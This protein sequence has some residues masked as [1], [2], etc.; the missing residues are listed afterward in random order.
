LGTFLLAAAG[1]FLTVSM[2]RAPDE[3]FSSALQGLKVWWEVV[4]PA[5]LPF[6]IGSEILMGLGVVNFMGVLLEPLMRPLFNVPGVGSFVM[7][8][9]LA[10]GYPIGAILTRKLRKQE[11]CNQVEAERLISFSNTADPLFMIGAVAVGM[12]GDARLGVVIAIAHYLAALAVGI[13][14]RFYRRNAPVSE[15]L[16]NSRGNIVV[17]AGKELYRARQRDGRPLGQLLGDAV[18]NSVN[19]L[20]MIG[21][22]IILFSVIMRIA[23]VSGLVAVVAQGVIGLLQMLGLSTNLS[24]AAVSGVFEITIG[25]N[26]ASQAVAPLAQRVIMAGAIIAWSGLSVHAQVAAVVN[27]TDIRILP[28]LCA[29]ALHAILAGLF[30]WLLWPKLS[31]TITSQAA[32]LPVFLQTVP[33]GS[34]HFWLERFLFMGQRVGLLLLVLLILSVAYHSLCRLQVVIWRRR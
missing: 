10:S 19:S 7:A 4:F 28:Y 2:V 14:M 11:L 26:V 31:P 30:T 12:F 3:A 29:R 16:S 23:T 8:M 13:C 32:S 9:G 27:D 6:F 33:N 1:L 34:L 24:S 21:G 5:L 15:Q 17:R 22:F 18:K 20:L 25:C